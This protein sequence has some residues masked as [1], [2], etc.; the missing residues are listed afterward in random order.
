MWD[1]YGDALFSVVDISWTQICCFRRK[2]MCCEVEEGE[3]GLRRQDEGVGDGAYVIQARFCGKWS[4]RFGHVS[5]VTYLSARGRLTLTLLA[6][7]LIARISRISLVHN[8]QFR[9]FPPCRDICDT[10]GSCYQ[11]IFRFKWTIYMTKKQGRLIRIIW[12]WK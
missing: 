10:P 11:K 3:P 6:E 8:H 1:I 2:N 9:V 7:R 12:H 5:Y 4:V